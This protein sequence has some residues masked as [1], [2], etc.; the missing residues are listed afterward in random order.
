MEY[1]PKPCENCRHTMT[2]DGEEIMAVFACDRIE[3]ECLNCCGCDDH[4]GEAWF[5]PS[6]TPTEQELEQAF[7]IVQSALIDNNFHT[8]S[9]L[10]DWA[11]WSIT[12]GVMVLELPDGLTPEDVSRVDDIARAEMNRIRQENWQKANE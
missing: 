6:N 1:S 11:W 7:T 3:D 12:P 4:S 5:T 8:L 2:E 9:I 10:L